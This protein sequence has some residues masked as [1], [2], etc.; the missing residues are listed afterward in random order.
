MATDVEM[1]GIEFQ[2][3]NDSED[4][5]KGIDELAKSLAELKKNI[6][7]SG[8]KLEALAK[9]I[10]ATGDA[11]KKE[12]LS[13]LSS[14]L[15]TI[16]NGLMPLSGIKLTGV[17]SFLKQMNT[18]SAE[19]LEKI[20]AIDF[21]N[22]KE[23]AE[24]AG[25]VLGVSKER[26]S[27]ATA[28]STPVGQSDEL[29]TSVRNAERFGE[30]L[31]DAKEKYKE[32]ANAAKDF[33]NVDEFVGKKSE[34]DILNMKLDELKV[35]LK[36]L[37]EAKGEDA[38]GVANLVEQIRKLQEQI[39][40][41]GNSS[42]KAGGKNR[43]FLQSL[44]R[45]AKYRAIRT[46]LH[47]ISTALRDGIQD[48]ARYSAAMNSSDAA[49]ANKTLSVYSS[50]L[51]Q[52]KN[53]IAAAAAPLLNFLLPAFQ[54][55]SNAV[56]NTTNHLNMLFSMINGQ[57]TY[58]K[59]TYNVVDYAKNLDSA[60]SS[61]NKLKNAVAGFDELN[62]LPD[63][64]QDAAA[65]NPAGI[66]YEDMFSEEKLTTGASGLAQWIDGLTA[67]E[68][69]IISITSY[70]TAKKLVSAIPNIWA[71]I[72]SLGINKSLNTTY[73]TGQKIASVAGA[74]VAGIGEFVT[75][76]SAV[77]DIAS[78]T[79]NIWTNLGEIVVSA[80]IAAAAMYSAFGPAGL[81]I[82]AITVLV[83]ALE[84]V[85]EAENEMVAK[86]SDKAFFEGT[87]ANLD[88]LGRAFEQL[89]IKI[90][91]PFE[92]V[93]QAAQ[94]VSKSKKYV[95]ETA[96]SIGRILKA[97][98]EGYEPTK[99]EVDKLKT[100]FSELSQTAKDTMD[101]TYDYLFDSI[102]GALSGALE[103]AGKSSAEVLAVLQKIRGEAKTEIDSLNKQFE[104]LSAKY[105]TGELSDK[106]FAEQAQPILDRIAELSGVRTEIS[107]EGTFDALLRD[108][109]N[110]NLMDES[111]L[112]AFFD[113]VSQTAKD[114]RSTV[115]D[116]VDGMIQA[117]KDYAN[118]ARALGREDFA[119]YLETNGVSAAETTRANA[120]GSL[121]D[122]LAA[123]FDA[124]Q[125]DALLKA[126]DYETE[127][128]E[129]YADMGAWR[130]FL[131][132]RKG[133]IGENGYISKY[134]PEYGDNDLKPLAEKIASAAKAAGSD[135]SA[136]VV[137]AFEDSLE[138]VF[139]FYIRDDIAF[140]HIRNYADLEDV[141][142]D[143]IEEMFNRRSWTHFGGTLRA[144]GGFP[145]VGE[146]FI[147]REAGP[148]M[149]GT[150]GGHTAVANND[151]IVEAVSAG[152]YQAVLSAMSAGDSRSGGQTRVVAT[153]VDGKVLFET[154][155]SEA[156][157][158]TVRTGYNR[159]LEV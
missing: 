131:L 65:T 107:V 25:A 21:S 144:G 26:I 37:L 151:Q 41:T 67:I 60:T 124:M 56:I 105:D 156:R 49:Q 85:V 119:K 98:Q 4:A 20:A 27:K 66:K 155:V 133:I 120:L 1:Q 113:N 42:K 109:G 159:L 116:E 83:G 102:T 108:A 136:W 55:L 121:D 29:D 97:F 3:V 43:E 84:G 47:G 64:K 69:L 50:T 59:A 96:T 2:I 77:E 7:N 104:S 149:V 152:V 62:I 141:I 76:K 6:G 48:L 24:N 91:Q 101:K 137:D 103:E 12:K 16:A 52:V 142:E 79:G 117:F 73:T 129:R 134:L 80:G 14:S 78:G 88:Q 92:S 61:A 45:I 35:K 123:L 89:A 70:L 8:T 51:M 18:V 54:S 128:K 30:S 158:D 94:E 57:S 63:N 147:A 111:E 23:A 32:T 130:Q 140:D 148:E 44:I 125:A 132:S 112:T 46:V 81:A 114:A 13:A 126:V 33:K 38:P 31:N 40:E 58:T 100:L 154:L 5:I 146:M 135:Y 153:T 71:K 17:T 118:T 127:L 90:K 72:K 87:G 53:S 36:N 115:N 19:N 74:A 122:Q 143:I 95:A 86:L 138:Q 99:A 110:L 82:A 106:Q 28:N 15:K 93:S 68:G 9:G 139:S 145:D 75:V 10:R 34:I 11:I 150:I 39:D 22:L 157:S